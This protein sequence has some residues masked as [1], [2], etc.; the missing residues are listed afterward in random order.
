MIK[1]NSSNIKQDYGIQVL[2][3]IRRLE[4]IS[5]KLGR[6]RAHQYFNLQCKHQELT[7]KSLRVRCNAVKDDPNSQKIIKKAEKDLL[8]NRIS[9]TIKHRRFLE[10]TIQNQSKDLADNII[11]QWA[12]VHRSTFK[13]I[14]FF[15]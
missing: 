5:R 12:K 1:F 2:Q 4:D 14:E 13:H 9:Q 10:K 15:G 7:P 11:R 6:Q 8:N 3:K